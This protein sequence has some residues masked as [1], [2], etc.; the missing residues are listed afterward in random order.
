MQRQLIGPPWLPVYKMLQNQLKLIKSLNL[1]REQANET[2]QRNNNPT[3]TET[4]MKV[5]LLRTKINN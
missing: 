5:A 4:F 1:K 3:A 2:W